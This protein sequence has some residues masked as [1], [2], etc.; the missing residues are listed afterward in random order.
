M[1]PCDIININGNK[2][3]DIEYTGVFHWVGIKR[4]VEGKLLA[5]RGESMKRKEGEGIWH[6]D[7]MSESEEDD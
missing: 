2:T 3:Y 7:S 1:W 6:F 5:P 4:Q